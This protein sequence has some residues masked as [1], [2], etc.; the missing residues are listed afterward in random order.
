MPA[1]TD[2]APT[3]VRMST[4]FLSRSSSSR[5]SMLQAVSASAAVNV[6]PVSSRLRRVVNISFSPLH[7]WRGALGDRRRTVIDTE[8]GPARF[9]PPPQA[10]RDT[11]NRA[12]TGLRSDDTIRP[13]HQFF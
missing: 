2:I 10:K 9:L 4:F 3:G 13:G 1:L 12:L 11:G 8:G 5:T 6:A 7:R